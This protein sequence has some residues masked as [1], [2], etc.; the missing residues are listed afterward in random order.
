MDGHNRNHP[1]VTQIQRDRY[2]VYSLVCRHQLL[3]Q[4]NHRIY[5]QIKPLAGQT[6][7]P[8]EEKQSYGQMGV[9]SRM[10]GSSRK[11]W[12]EDQEDGER[13]QRLWSI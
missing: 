6:D 13:Q 10:G 3:N 12:Q 2:G 5:R 4:Q 8:R 7:L 11:V 1:G 9:E